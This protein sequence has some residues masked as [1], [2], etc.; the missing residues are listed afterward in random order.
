M[1][2]KTHEYNKYFIERFFTKLW[3]GNHL[4]QT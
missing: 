1:N 2:I 3:L 4:N